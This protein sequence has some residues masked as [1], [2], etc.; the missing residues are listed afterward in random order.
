MSRQ[1]PGSGSRVLL[2]RAGPLEPAL[3][4][5]EGRGVEGVGGAAAAAMSTAHD[6]RVAVARGATIV[7]RGV[8]S[9]ATLGQFKAQLVRH[10]ECAGRPAAWIQ[11]SSPHGGV[12]AD[13][14][15]TL[16]D[17]GV[18]SGPLEL[19]LRPPMAS[20]T[21]RSTLGPGMAE[22]SEGFRLREVFTA[23]DAD[24]SGQIDAAELRKV[25]R[26]FGE[27]TAAGHTFHLWSHFSV[28]FFELTESG[29]DAGAVGLRGRRDPGARFGSLFAHLA[30]FPSH[31][32]CR[33]WL[34]FGEKNGRSDGR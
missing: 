11:L 33:L 20:Q 8:S 15:L 29:R 12:L 32:S 9:A 6:V 28:V 24:G 18:T 31:V 26:L 10:R 17:Y 23:F 5:A 25:R 27:T 16:A 2:S 4:K 13:D 30:H 22:A 1:P 7:V 19:S 21:Q 14:G 34:I 3:E